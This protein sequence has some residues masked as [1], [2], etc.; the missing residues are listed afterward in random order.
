[1]YNIK[2]MITYQG[3]HALVAFASSFSE[4]EHPLHHVF[5][6]VFLLNL[7]CR[8]VE[9]LKKGMYVFI[10]SKSWMKQIKLMNSIQLKLDMTNLSIS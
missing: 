1:M 4:G 9:E 3:L 6:F 2:M 8:N 5:F 7:E 10:Y